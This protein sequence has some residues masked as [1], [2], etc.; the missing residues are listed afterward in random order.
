MNINIIRAKTSWRN[1][2]KL[3]LAMT[4]G[5]AYGEFRDDLVYLADNSFGIREIEMDPRSAEALG[6]PSERPRSFHYVENDFGQWDGF[7][8]AESLEVFWGSASSGAAIRARKLANDNWEVEYTGCDTTCR[9]ESQ[10]ASIFF[11]TVALNTV[12]YVHVHDS[13][14]LIQQLES[15]HPGRPEGWADVVAQIKHATVEARNGQLSR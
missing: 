9:I 1:L 8:A 15:D 6:Y 11:E 7:S 13:E 4:G 3:S 2:C 14:A 10:Y 12:E 5:E